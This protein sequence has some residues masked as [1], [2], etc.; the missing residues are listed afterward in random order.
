M[1]REVTNQLSILAV[2]SPLRETNKA[3]E[4][5]GD[6]EV[7][8]KH[9]VVT[10]LNKRRSKKCQAIVVFNSWLFSSFLFFSFFFSFFALDGH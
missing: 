5:N 6:G 2:P 10:S 9:Q 3:A 7:T 1:P 8:E 4:R